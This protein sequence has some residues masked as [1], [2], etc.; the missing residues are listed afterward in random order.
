MHPND[1]T[2]ECRMATDADLA[3]EAFDH[4]KL[5]AINTCPTWGIL[6]YQ[7]HKSVRA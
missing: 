7:M 6:R 3:L 2:C 5:A 1:Y 4:T